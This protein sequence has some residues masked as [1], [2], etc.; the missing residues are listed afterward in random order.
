[1]TNAAALCAAVIMHRM[2]R[3]CLRRFK[4]WSLCIPG[5]VEA[6]YLQVPA[7]WTRLGSLLGLVHGIKVSR[8]YFKDGCLVSGPCHVLLPCGWACSAAKVL[9]HA[10]VPGSSSWGVT[11]CQWLG[12]VEKLDGRIWQQQ[13]VCCTANYAD[14]EGRS[15][16]C[17]QILAFFVLYK[18]H[19]AIRLCYLAQD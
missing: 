11:H 7:G 17:R 2:M 15:I 14:V 10:I 5:S 19:K 16:D 1:M 9:V 4:P 8:A 13:R 3:I 12:P 6:F 18:L